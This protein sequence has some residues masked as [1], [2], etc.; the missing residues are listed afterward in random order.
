VAGIKDV[1]QQAIF[2]FSVAGSSVQFI[3]DWTQAT[4]FY[5]IKDTPADQFVLLNTYQA[6]SNNNLEYSTTPPRTASLYAQLPMPVSLSSVVQSGNGLGDLSLTNSQPV[7]FSVDRPPISGIWNAGDGIRSSKP[8]LVFTELNEP[9]ARAW[10][11]VQGTSNRNNNAATQQL[12]AYLQNYYDDPTQFGNSAPYHYGLIPEVEV[13]DNKGTETQKHYNLGRISRAAIA[14]MPDGL[15]VYMGDTV[16]YGVL[17]MYVGS[18]DRSA[19][20]L[21]AAQWQQTDALDGGRANIVW[22]KLGDGSDAGLKSLVDNGLQFSQIFTT[23]DAP[24][25][26]F[27]EI[28]TRDQ[29]EYLKLVDFQENTAAFMET[30][31]YAAMLGATAEFQAIQGFAVNEANKQLYMSIA[32]I[33]NSMLNNLQDST[34]DMQI[35]RIAAGAVYSLQLS[36]GQKDSRR[37]DIGSAYVATSMQAITALLGEDLASADADGNLS[38][39]DKVAN[40]ST[41]RYSEKMRTLFIAENGKR[42][43]NNSL[44]A[45]NVDSRQLSRLASVPAG[46]AVSGLELQE[47]INGFAYLFC[48]YQ[49][50]GQYAPQMS[51]TLATDLE[52]LINRRE[53]KVAYMQLPRLQ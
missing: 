33:D 13:F 19:G 5:H 4:A 22:V 7:D 28:K 14:I 37:K 20:S 18:A 43:I 11:S 30:R 1:N 32:N 42:H 15:T 36:S 35:R 2:D 24:A 44:W 9:D 3:S 38:N 53:T 12:N 17:L 47:N 27:T 40:P 25:N 52:S 29:V 48:A 16:P 46:A 49:H 41:L 51:A 21:Y 34:D 45:Y 23:S 26:G 6:V 39:V 31:R 8:S 10:E 50:A